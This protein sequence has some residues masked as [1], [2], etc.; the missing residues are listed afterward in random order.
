MPVWANAN[1]KIAVEDT[2]K[3]WKDEKGARKE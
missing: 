1:H 3:K 2:K